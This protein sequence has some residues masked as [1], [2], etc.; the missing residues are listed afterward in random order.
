M[1][2]PDLKRVGIQ[3]FSIPK[4]LEQDF[5]KSIEMLSRMGYDEVELFGPFPFSSESAKSSWTALAPMLGFSGSG[6]FGHTPAEVK[7]ILTDNGI[8]VPSI[9]TDLDTLENHME[10][11]GAAGGEIGFTYVGLPAIP[12]DRRT[13]PDDYKRMADTFNE[14]G[15]AAKRAGLKLAYHNH[16]YGLQ[17]V[18]GQIPLRIILD[19]T[20][21][22]L[23]FFELDIYWTTAGG[24]DPVAYLNDYPGRYHLMHL[25]DMK[26][27]K[28]YSGDGND[29]GQWIELFPYMTSA[30]KGILDLNNIIAAARQNG[31]R[32]FFVEQDLVQDPEVALQDSLNFLKG[33]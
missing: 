22:E 12:E 2:T 28:H 19:G 30:G 3:L 1:D 18:D 25:K 10:A 26:E 33:R 27:L 17:E 29:S 32:H 13:S 7:A 23:V 6:Y 20:D 8:T 5:R 15:A 21:P 4:L 24:A 9:H 31:V 16:G 14:I 11:L